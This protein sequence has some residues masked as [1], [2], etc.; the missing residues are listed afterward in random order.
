MS[1]S[2]DQGGRVKK[3]RMRKPKAGNSDGLSSVAQLPTAQ[4]S[5]T[6]APVAREV[7]DS[8]KGLLFKI[9]SKLDNLEITWNVSAPL[10]TFDEKLSEA[11]STLNRQNVLDTNA[12]ASYIEDDDNYINELPDEILVLILCFVSTK[13]AIRMS[14]VSRRWKNLWLKVPKVEFCYGHEALKVIFR[15]PN[16]KMYESVN[17]VNQVMKLH[18][19]TTLEELT[20]CFPLDSNYSYDINRWSYKNFLASPAASRLYWLKDLY[21]RGINVGDKVIECLFSNSP[22]IGRLSV[23]G[24]MNLETVIIADAPNLKYLNLTRCNF[25]SRLDISAPNLNIIKLHLYHCRPYANISAPV[26][27]RVSIAFCH[28]LSAFSSAHS[29]SMWVVLKCL[30]DLLGQFTHVNKILSL[31][32]SRDVSIYALY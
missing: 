8:S 7:D 27:S 11:F 26:L 28:I 9:I 13:E 16:F 3:L 4:T 21:L 5:K 29:Y 18:N 14:L 15:P 12:F 31:I 32:V 10:G 24:S 6:S 17:L 22:F 1:A 19:T 25:L 30:Q 23:I 2:R 20:I